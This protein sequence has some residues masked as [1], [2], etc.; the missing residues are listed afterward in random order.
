MKKYVLA[1]ALTLSISG[2]AHAEGWLD[3]LKGFVG[4][5]ESTEQVETKTEAVAEEVK[6]ASSSLDILGLVGSVSKSLNVSDE[7]AEGGMA[8]LFNLAKSSL[9]DTDYSTLAKSLPGADS[10][11]SKIPDVSSL[12]GNSDSGV[13]GLLSKASQYSDSLKSI[14]AVKQQFEALGLK[15]E[16]ITK[17]ISQAQ[18]YLDTEQGQQ[19]KALLMKGVSAF[20]S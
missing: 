2:A 7:Q 19:A 3:S 16:M 18:S 12:T 4:L 17:Y 13:G 8:S 10:L 20:T 9:G 5:D 6:E 11:L 14:N 15:P 1:C